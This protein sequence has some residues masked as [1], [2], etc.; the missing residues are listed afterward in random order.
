MGQAEIRRRMDFTGLCQESVRDND[1]AHGRL[2]NPSV[3][4][5]FLTFHSYEVKCGG[6]H[7]S[8]RQSEKPSR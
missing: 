8:S 2:I 1:S 4:V 5:I 3:G 7:R 6:E